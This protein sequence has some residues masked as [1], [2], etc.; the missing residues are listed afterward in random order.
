M[1][2]FALAVVLSVSTT[3]FAA[4][5]HHSEGGSSPS[6]TSSSGGS[7]SGGGYSGSSSGGYSGGSSH[8]SGSSGGGGY[9]GGGSSHSSGSSGGYSGGSHSSGA[10]SYSGGGSSHSGGGSHSNAGSSH[11]GGSNNAGNSHFS[12]ENGSARSNVRSSTNSVEHGGTFSG[13]SQTGGATAD[14]FSTLRP[15]S[16]PSEAWMHKSFTLDIS[17][18]N[19]NKA[20]AHHEFD[21][22]LQTVGLESNK[23]AYR[24]KVA[25]IGIPFKEGHRSNWIA[26]IF[27]AK[28]NAAKHNAVPQLRPCLTKECKPIPVP[29]KPCVG[30]KCPVPSPTPVPT[31]STGVCTNGYDA[32]GYCAPWGYVDRCST[33]SDYCYVRFARVNSNYCGLILQEI[34]REQVAYRQLE[35]TQQSSCTVA[36]QTPECE[37]AT[38]RLEKWGN[39]IFQLQHQYQICQTASGRTAVDPSLTSDPTAQPDPQSTRWPFFSPPFF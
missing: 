36:P 15:A 25:A 4:A 37:Q 16:T 9:S 24:E 22:K 20:M 28:A 10:P 29:P 8:S 1:K 5:Q 12:H 18:N 32:H 38:Q 39:H 31:P 13:A 27:G 21:S 19:L 34:R 26:R 35:Q 23:S 11:S 30:K 2:R 17:A 14:R 7:S 33:Q 6:S 3:H